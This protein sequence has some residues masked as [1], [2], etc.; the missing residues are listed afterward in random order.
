MTEVALTSFLLMLAVTYALCRDEG[1][2]LLD[3]RDPALPLTFATL[4]VCVVFAYIL[5]CSTPASADIL[6]A[7]ES[8]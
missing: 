8:R 2:S 6:R 5:L 4:A 1:D 3:F 7:L